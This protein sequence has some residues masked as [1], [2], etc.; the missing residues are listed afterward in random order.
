MVL[1]DTN[2]GK[3]LTW[4]S[5]IW[6]SH[7]WAHFFL[8]S[9]R[10]AY[11]PFKIALN[12]SDS[13][14][15]LGSNLR[16]WPEIVG[17]GRSSP[18]LCHRPGEQQSCPRCSAEGRPGLAG[19]WWSVD[20]R[21]CRAPSRARSAISPSSRWRPGNCRGGGPRWAE[22]RRT[23]ASRHLS[24]TEENKP[25]CFWGR[26][27]E[28]YVQVT[29]ATTAHPSIFLNCIL[30]LFC[31]CSVTE[32]GQKIICKMWE[33]FSLKNFQIQTHKGLHPQENAI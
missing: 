29:I 9:L 6:W 27:H 20:P 15:F 2:T 21:C 19:Q 3:T 14:R 11:R 32:Q 25:I 4:N 33:F 8:K 13:E 12:C 1:N 26:I 30:H 10:G 5:H 17:K 7:P 22:C 18:G 31:A 16:S 24:G 23:R 28:S